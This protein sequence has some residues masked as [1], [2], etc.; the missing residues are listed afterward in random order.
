[1]SGLAVLTLALVAASAL[2]TAELSALNDLLADSDAALADS[3]R[4][5]DAFLAAVSHQ[6]RTPLAVISGFVVAMQRRPSDGADRQACNQPIE[7]NVRRLD[8]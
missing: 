7:R 6:L 1:M 2:R 8:T 5:K 4:T 3:S